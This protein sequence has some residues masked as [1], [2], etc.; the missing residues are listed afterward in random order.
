MEQEPALATDKLG[1]DVAPFQSNKAVMKFPATQKH[2]KRWVNTF[3]FY[4]PIL[5]RKEK[6]TYGSA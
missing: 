3:V 5:A 1:A 6:H 2:I 4:K